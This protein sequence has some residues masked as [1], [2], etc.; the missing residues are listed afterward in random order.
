MET[1]QT[2]GEEKSGSYNEEVKKF[3][4]SLMK[5]YGFSEAEASAI[6]LWDT[7]LRALYYAAPPPSD[8]TL[9]LSKLYYEI[10]A[11]V[12]IVYNI[13]IMQERRTEDVT[14]VRRALYAVLADE[15]GYKASEICHAAGK[16]R[17][18]VIYNLNRQR[19]L[20]SCHTQDQS[21]KAAK[22]WRKIITDYAKEI[23]ERRDDDVDRTEAVC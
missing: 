17:T 11:M 20:L 22:R 15:Y 8:T 12:T 18:T 7:K 9:N 5:R 23:T 14:E 13:D 2:Y 4:R 16:D 10:A 21:T 3:V 6:V 1:H 19:E